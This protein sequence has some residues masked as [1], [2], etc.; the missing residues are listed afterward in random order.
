MFEGGNWNLFNLDKIVYPFSTDHDNECIL[1]VKVSMTV[2]CY[3]LQK[4]FLATNVSI[5]GDLV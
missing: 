3:F 5:G 4:G 2:S 1:E